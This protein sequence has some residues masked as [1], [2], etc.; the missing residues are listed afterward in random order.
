MHAGL[1]DLGAG[2]PVVLLHSSCYSR[3]QWR[4]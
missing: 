2:E 1:D 4:R 3:R